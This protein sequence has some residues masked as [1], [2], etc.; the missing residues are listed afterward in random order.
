VPLRHEHVA[1]LARERRLAAQHDELDLHGVGATDGD[2]VLA[3]VLEIDPCAG[4]VDRD[5]FGG[6]D[7]R[8]ETHVEAAAREAQAQR[9][10]E[11]DR[12]VAIEIDL[13]A[14]GEG[15]LDATAVGAEAIAGPAG[16]RARRL[17][18]A[19]RSRRARPST[20]AAM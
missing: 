15:E 14:V 6:V 11:L 10:P 19:L 3:V 18:L 12:G 5:G 2:A 16:R 13:A 17:R 8:R 1:G 20:G 9:I 4:A 7:G